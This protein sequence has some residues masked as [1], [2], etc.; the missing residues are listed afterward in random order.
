MLRI[1]LDIGIP[2][3]CSWSEDVNVL[4]GGTA[5]WINDIIAVKWATI[6]V[7]DAVTTHAIKRIATII[8]IGDVDGGNFAI[9]V[10]FCAPSG[11]D[12][13]ERGVDIVGDA[14]KISL[15]ENFFNLIAKGLMGVSAVC[16]IGENLATKDGMEEAAA[17]IYREIVHIL[18][19]TIIGTAGMRLVPVK[20]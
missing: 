8:R 3:G 16:A 7:F 18:P 14:G 12:M 13:C 1:L 10:V 2:I 17:R 11:D 19:I 4:K 15:L 5:T 9:K 6:E 20:E